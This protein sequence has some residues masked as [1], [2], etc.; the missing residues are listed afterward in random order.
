MS[1]PY[2]PHRRRVNR[3]RRSGHLDTTTILSDEEA[4]WQLLP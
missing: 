4:S 2:H 3:D 1:T